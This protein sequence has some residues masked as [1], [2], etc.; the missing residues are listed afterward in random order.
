M[1][2]IGIPEDNI[3]DIF[4]ATKDIRDKYVLSRLIF[5]LGLTEEAKNILL[6]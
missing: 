1:A 6:N 4:E 3:G 2:D 5:D